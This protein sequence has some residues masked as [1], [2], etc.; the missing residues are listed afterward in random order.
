VG[1]ETGESFINIGW[2]RFTDR[3]HTRLVQLFDQVILLSFTRRAITSDVHSHDG[4]SRNSGAPRQ[5]AEQD[6]GDDRDR[7]FLHCRLVL[8]ARAK[9]AVQARTATAS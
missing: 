4:V 8:L 6:A 7:R 2:Q 9:A 5:N 3:R 1:N